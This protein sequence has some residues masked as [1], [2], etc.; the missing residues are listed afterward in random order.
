MNLLG[1]LT[2]LRA[3]TT[4]RA[5]VATMDFD[6]L[7]RRCAARPLVLPFRLPPLPARRRKR[8]SRRWPA[9]YAGMPEG[10]RAERAAVADAPGH[11]AGP[12]AQPVVGRMQQ[13]V[14]CPGV[15]ELRRSCSPMSPPGRWTASGAEEA[16]AAHAGRCRA[17]HHPYHPRPGWPRRPQAAIK[18]SDGEIVADSA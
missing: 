10:P 5:D 8:T 16:L 11:E 13:R 2:A 12:P 15:D 4:S 3:A 7:A 6:A 17:H 18:I 9:I 1:C 14:D